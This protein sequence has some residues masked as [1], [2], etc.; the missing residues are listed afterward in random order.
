MYK[1]KCCREHLQQYTAVGRRNRN[2]GPAHIERD[3]LR[4]RDNTIFRRTSD[5]SYLIMP[6]FRRIVLFLL[7]LFIFT[8]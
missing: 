1:K 7:L 8:T 4:D 5:F 2:T 3:K 6:I